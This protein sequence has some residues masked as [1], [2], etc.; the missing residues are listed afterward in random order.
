MILSFHL[1]PMGDFLTS[2]RQ[3]L[4]CLGQ[5]G[6]FSGFGTIWKRWQQVEKTS[7]RALIRGCT[8]A[9]SHTA[10]QLLYVAQG[11][12]WFL[13]TS[14]TVCVNTYDHHEMWP[15]AFWVLSDLHLEYILYLQSVKL[16]SIS[17][18]RLYLIQ[19]EYVGFLTR[20]PQTSCSEGIIATTAFVSQIRL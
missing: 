9:L 6:D 19:P 3:R 1:S 18:F 10:R 5:M 15:Y 12:I 4:L 8:C 2:A 17:F 20:K 16:T 11:C 7:F 14:S 13:N